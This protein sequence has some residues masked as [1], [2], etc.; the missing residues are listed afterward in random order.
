MTPKEQLDKL[1]VYLLAPKEEVDFQLDYNE[2]ALILG[3]VKQ[4]LNELEALKKDVVRYFELRGMNPFLWNG[5]LNK[6][7]YDLEEKIK[8]GLA[9]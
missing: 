3:D 5:N 1:A 4:S 6:E 8:K 9:K 7:F 2:I